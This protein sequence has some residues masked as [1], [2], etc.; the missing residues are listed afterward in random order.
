M[1]VCSPY[2]PIP[3]GPYL[4]TPELAMTNWKGCGDGHGYLS[5]E[6]AILDGSTGLTRTFDDYYQSTTGLAGSFKYELGVTPTT[7][8]CLFAPNHVD[9]L[10]VTLAVGLC[11]A[12]VTPV[13]P[14]YKANELLLILDKSRSTVLVAHVSTL[15]VALEAA[16]NAKYVKHI[17]LMTEFDNDDDEAAPVVL[18]EGVIPLNSIK[19]HD[20][21]FQKTVRSHHPHTDAHPFVLPYS[22]GTTG[23]PKGVCLTHANL[24]ANLLQCA[25]VEGLGFAPVSGMIYIYC[26]LSACLPACLLL[27][28][29]CDLF[30]RVCSFFIS[31]PVIY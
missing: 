20:K 21:A 8:V 23:M 17:I 9:Y 2:P 18:P 26:C 4:P 28:C 30:V 14:L 12:K 5:Q 6:I 31:N 22:S 24:T 25:Q 11:G 7:T 13:N 10:P 19:K 16:K 29:H 27:P 3:P 15:D 1:Y